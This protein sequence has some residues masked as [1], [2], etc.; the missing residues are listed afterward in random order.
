MNGGVKNVLRM[1]LVM[2]KLD[3]CAKSVQ[4][5]DPMLRIQ[6]VFSSSTVDFLDTAVRD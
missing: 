4:L 3:Q 6:I 5:E 1:R 2:A